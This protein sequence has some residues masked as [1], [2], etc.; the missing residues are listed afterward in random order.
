[1]LKLS[2]RQGAYGMK[3]WF[4]LNNCSISRFDIRK[5]EILISYINRTDHLPA[6][7]ISG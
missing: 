4:Q 1:M 5:D 6:Q 2:W 7:L 3:S